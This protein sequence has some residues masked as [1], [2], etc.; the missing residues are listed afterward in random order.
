MLRSATARFQTSKILIRYG[1]FLRRKGKIV[2]GRVDGLEN[3][4][5]Q[6]SMTL[7]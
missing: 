7:L 3:E 1:R 4:L 2:M 6:F 5:F